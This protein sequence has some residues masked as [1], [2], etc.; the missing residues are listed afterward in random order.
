MSDMISNASPRPVKSAWTKSLSCLYRYNPTGQY[1]ARVR[2]GGK[3]YRKALET[4]DYQ[5]ARRKLSTFKT[6]LG[7]TDPSAGK[8][9]FGKVLDTYAETIGGAASSQE[10]KRAI[11]KKLKKTWLGIDKFPLRTIKPSDVA[12]WLTKNCGKKSASYYNSVLSLIRAALDSAVRDRIISQAEHPAAHLRYRK[13]AKPIR[14]TP[15]PEE[16]QAIVADIRAQPFNREAQTSGDF[17]EFLGLAGLGQAE[18]AGIT[19]ADVDLAAGRIILYR[20]KTSTGFSIPIFPQVRPLVER[21][22]TAKAHNERLFSIREARKALANACTRLGLPNFTHRALRRMFITRALERGVDVKVIAEWQGH[23]D[24]GKLIL[25]TYSH[26]RRP[27]SDR[28]AA[29][30]TDGE[31]ENVIAMSKAGAA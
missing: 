16:F 17:I 25:Q 26:I 23:S 11:I 15:T 20:H 14:L 10:D 1:F 18:A 27:H 6:D 31:P 13:R 3:L 7:N 21:L 4:P 12:R 24:G 29:L 8:T 19:R 5:E 30:M 2:F 9:S 28:M 22:C